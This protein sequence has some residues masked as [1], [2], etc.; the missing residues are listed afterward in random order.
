MTMTRTLSLIGAALLGASFFAHAQAPAPAGA[1][2]KGGERHHM[3]REH[4]KGAHAACKDKADR[5]SC[6]R[7]QMCAKSADPAKCQ[8][9]SKARMTKHLEARQIAH[10]A[11]NGKRGDELSKCLSDKMPKHRGHG[12]HG[13]HSEKPKT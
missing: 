4:M 2:G 6:M 7:E 11:C 13:G 8:V 9:E 3:M 5:R 10:E 1:D 12:G